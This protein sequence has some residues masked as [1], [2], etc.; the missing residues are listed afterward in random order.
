[1]TGKVTRRDFL[2]LLTGVGI[3]S[4]VAVG[5]ATMSTEGEEEMGETTTGILEIC[6]DCEV[7]VMPMQLRD[8]ASGAKKRDFLITCNAGKPVD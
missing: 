5:V 2:R 3:G 1:M 4:A 7:Y 8:T 6:A